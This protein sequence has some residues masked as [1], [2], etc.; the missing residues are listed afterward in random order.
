MSMSIP[1]EGELTVFQVHELR[2]QWLAALDSERD[3]TVD[4]AEMTEIDGAGVQLLLAL[5][6]E[7]RM[8]GARVRV[9]NPSAQAAAM[10]ELLRLDAELNASPAGSPGREHE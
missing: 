2:T 3:L 9:L 1:I 6:N 10:L 7:A 8:R 4:L 5:R